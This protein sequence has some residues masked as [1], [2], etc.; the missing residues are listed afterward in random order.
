M[1]LAAM[2][3]TEGMAR[4]IQ[5]IDA[6]LQR[7]QFN[8]SVLNNQA[9]HRHQQQQQQP[10]EWR[11]Y[12]PKALDLVAIKSRLRPVAPNTQ[13]P[14]WRVE[15]MEW[16]PS[17]VTDTRHGRRDIREYEM[18]E[19]RQRLTFLLDNRYVCQCARVC[20]MHL[21]TDTHSPASVVLRMS[22]RA[23]IHARSCWIDSSRRSR[24]LHRPRS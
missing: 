10:Q 4:F 23:H 13:L 14:V 3:C 19:P 18:L 21:S 24:R 17:Y 1:A 8:R 2:Q 12:A 7:H 22:W 6:P 5:A 15:Q 20:S 16:T 11:S 9:Y